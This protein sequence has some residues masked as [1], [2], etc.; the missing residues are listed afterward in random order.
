MRTLFGHA[1]ILL[2]LV[3][4]PAWAHNLGAECKIRG[5]RV[6]LEAYFDDDTPA[7]N[8]KVTLRDASSHVLVEGTTDHDGRWSI[9]VPKPGNYQVIVDAGDGHRHQQGLT[10][11]DRGAATG[12]T[13]AGGGPSR[14]EFT[15]TPWLKI[16]LG[17]AL[18]TLA[19]G[20]VYA[21]LRRTRSPSNSKPTA[22]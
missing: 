9:P 18:I 2:L 19:T 15:R 20:G 16:A 7:R 22:A 12:S 11:V 17:L 4:S 8:A 13:I 1:V 6:E 14:D 3:A 10:V 21:C 5:G